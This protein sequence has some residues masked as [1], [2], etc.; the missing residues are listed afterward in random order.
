MIVLCEP[1]PSKRGLPG[2]EAVMDGTIHGGELGHGN[3]NK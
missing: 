1:A 2:N 3:S